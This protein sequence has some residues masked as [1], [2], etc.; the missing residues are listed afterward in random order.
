MRDNNRLITFRGITEFFGG[1]C[2]QIPQIASFIWQHSRERSRSECQFC[3][4]KFVSG[5]MLQLSSWS[6]NAALKCSWQIFKL[7]LKCIWTARQPGNLMMR[8]IHGKSEIFWCIILSWM[9]KGNNVL[10]HI[11]VFDSFLLCDCHSLTD[12][13]RWF[14]DFHLSVSPETL[15]ILFRPFC[16]KFVCAVSPTCMCKVNTVHSQI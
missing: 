6:F 16:V 1:R 7:H 13:I 15:C 14:L 4:H 5:V 9:L 3:W 12:S 2:K 11:L 8:C 10:Y